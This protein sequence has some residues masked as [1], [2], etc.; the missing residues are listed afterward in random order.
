M[1]EG[2]GIQKMVEKI[3]YFRRNAFADDPF[4]V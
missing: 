1:E 3:H 2:G 4:N